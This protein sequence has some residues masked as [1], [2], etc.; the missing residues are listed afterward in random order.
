[1]R[2]L[3]VC[4]ATF[5]VE[6]V[7]DVVI[8]LYSGRFVKALIYLCR[9][10]EWA[11]SFYEARASVKPFSVSPLY[12]VSGSRRRYI[13]DGGAELSSGS[14]AW[15][16][17]SFVLSDS[18][19]L[20]SI[21]SGGECLVS[22]W[23]RRV[24]VSLKTLEFTPLKSLSIGFADPNKQLIKMVF[25][26]PILLSSKLMAPPLESFRKRLEKAENLYILYPSTSHICNY[27]S[28]LWRSA[29]GETLFGG[30]SDEW[31]DYFLGRLCEVVLT[32]IDLDVKPRTV[33]YDEKRSIRGFIGYAILKLT[34]SKRKI[35]EKIDK[36]MALANIFG[37]GKS[38]SIGFGVTTVLT[39]PISGFQQ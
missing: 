30:P 22:I 5:D 2:V 19:K 26:T 13:L 9:E 23:G 24:R 25:H 32:P 28:K 7:D 4:R 36:L 8:S 38:R 10:F 17:L 31:S 27:L 29:T 18:S 1:M 37:I 15:F 39:T 6:A 34:I 21:A 16:D 20:D 33:K 14:R 12:V 3:L 35:V 11:K